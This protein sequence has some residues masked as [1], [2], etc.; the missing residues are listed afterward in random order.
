MLK[1]EFLDAELMAITT[2]VQRLVEQR[3]S[4]TL[5]MTYQEQWDSL[6]I[7]VSELL[8]FLSQKCNKIHK[9]AAMHYA[10]LVHFVEGRDPLLL[11]NTPFFPASEYF[12][13][14]GRQF[15]QFKQSVLK[16]QEEA[17]AREDELLQK[18]LE[19]EAALKLKDDL[20]AK[21]MNQQPQPQKHTY[22]HFFCFFILFC[23]VSY[24]FVFF[25]LYKV[26]CYSES[27]L[28][29]NDFLYFS[30]AVICFFCY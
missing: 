5:H 14:E 11:A 13:R 17:K 10:T 12:T 23:F 7:R 15:K 6:Q 22:F 24:N 19:L 18:Q 28:F 26:V 30:F 9:V 3:R 16:Q 1:S 27:F 20:I 29:I 2:E 21:L 25:C 4:P 8:S